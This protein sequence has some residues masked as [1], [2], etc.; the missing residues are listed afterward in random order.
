MVAATKVPGKWHKMANGYRR[1]DCKD[2]AILN[3]W[4]S[5]GTINFQGPTEKADA[6]R[7]A[8]RRSASRVGGSLGQDLARELRVRV[9]AR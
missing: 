7:K 4:P 6:F 1:F 5:T 8:L 3:W 2:G 9:K